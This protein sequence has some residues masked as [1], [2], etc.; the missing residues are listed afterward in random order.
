MAELQADFEL[1]PRSEIEAD[2]ELP[3]RS[4]IEATFELN[5]NADGRDAKINGVN[6]LTLTA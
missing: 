3:R 1:V 2:I 4:D 5:V 6:T